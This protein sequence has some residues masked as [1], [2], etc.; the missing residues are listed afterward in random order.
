MPDAVLRQ[1]IKLEWQWGNEA[2]K[3]LYELPTLQIFVNF[4]LIFKKE[5]G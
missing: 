2:L 4:T 3:P 1:S 5:L